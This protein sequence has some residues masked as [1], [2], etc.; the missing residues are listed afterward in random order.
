M[1]IL[2]ILHVWTMYHDYMHR[3]HISLVFFYIYFNC[4]IKN[5]IGEFIMYFFLL[6]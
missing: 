2:Q 3:T 4:T 5:F 1:F 6:S